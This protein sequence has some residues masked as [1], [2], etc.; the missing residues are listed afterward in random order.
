MRQLA[1]LRCWP[2]RARSRCSTTD[3]RSA[4]SC[5]PPLRPAAAAPGA[6]A[7]AARHR[8]G[9]GR[10]P[11]GWHLLADVGAP[12]PREL[13]AHAHADTLSCLVHVDGEPLLVDTGTSTYAPGPVR[14]TSG[15]PR[16]T[17]PWKWTARLDRG[18]GSVPGRPPGPGHRAVGLHRARRDGDGRGRP[19]RLPGPA[20]P[21]APPPPV[22]AARRRA[23]GRGHVTGR[24]RHAHRLRWHLAPGAGC[25][26]SRRGALVTTAAGEF[27]VT[28][29]ATGPIALT[30]EPAAGRRRVRPH[31][32]APVLVC[33]CTRSCR[34]GSAPAGSRSGGR[35]HRLA[36]AARA[37]ADRGTR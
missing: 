1:A 12:C 22:D 17:T 7:G 24:G 27:R 15:Q 34:C 10:R 8:P 20:R 9:P 13:P 36:H 28:V 19:R 33:R 14:A 23:A 21:A 30:A 11:G 32:G 37:P 29:T 25:G 4:R 2:R 18:L 26:W 5:W 6:A 31:L 3:T 35:D 16:R